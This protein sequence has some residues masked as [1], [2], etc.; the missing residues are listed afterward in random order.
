MASVTSDHMHPSA[1]ASVGGLHRYILPFKE[2]LPS[3]Q[4]A[5]LYPPLQVVAA[6]AAILGSPSFVA[7]PPLYTIAAVFSMVHTKERVV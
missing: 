7:S 3:S 1:H 2:R 5:P 4:I 6:L